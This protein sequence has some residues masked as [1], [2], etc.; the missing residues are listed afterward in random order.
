[1][2]NIIR[3]YYSLNNIIHITEQKINTAFYKTEEITQKATKGDKR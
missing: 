2:K 1:M 3:N